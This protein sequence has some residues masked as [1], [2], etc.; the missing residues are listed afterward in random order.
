M[1]SS[2]PK[3]NTQIILNTAMQHIHV[4]E[5]KAGLELLHKLESGG[6]ND[7]R[8]FRTIGGVYERLGENLLARKYFI[9]SLEINPSQSD[10]HHAVAAN[11]L[12][13]GDMQ[14]A[15]HQC[16]K[17]LKIA[18]NNFNIWLVKAKCE[19]ELRH[20][21]SAHLSFQKAVD[22][23]PHDIQV[24]LHYANLQMKLGLMDQ[25]GTL[26]RKA[27]KIAPQDINVKV[28]YAWF[29]R[30]SGKLQDASLA[31]NRLLEV[32]TD[33]ADA[34]EDL[35]LTYLDLGEIQNALI[36]LTEGL[37]KQPKN[38][39]LHRTLCSLRYETGDNDYTASLR[40]AQ[41]EGKIEIAAE[42]IRQLIVGDELDQAQ[43]RL[44]KLLPDTDNILLTSVLQISIWKKQK[45]FT[46][47]IRFFEKNRELL[48]SHQQVLEIVVVALLAE[49]AYEQADALV[50]RLVKNHPFDQ[51]YL[52]L[53]GI[54]KRH[55][56]NE[57]YSYLCNFEQL[58]SA[59]ELILPSHYKSL[60]SFNSLL[61][62]T[63]NDV[64][65]MQQN[66]LSQS[67]RGGTQTSGRLF[68]RPHPIIRDLKS[69]LATTAQRFLTTLQKDPSHP[70]TSRIGKDIELTA[71]WSIRLQNAGYHVPHI[72]SKGWYSSAY[73]VSLPEI[74]HDKSGWLGIGKSGIELQTPQETE[75]WIKP[76][77]GTL[78]LFPS[79]FWHGTE[80]FSDPQ[81][82]LSVAF[83]IL[84]TY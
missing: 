6:L 1:N 48:I 17:A 67:V 70:I 24:L 26:L 10:L 11:Q 41:S 51:F 21:G 78:V 5:L 66:P 4:G 39:S 59:Q 45:R 3:Q 52:A 53:K 76:E 73:Y 65:S 80:P 33:T 49:A 47:I 29:L 71:S 36:T 60:D 20:Y 77:V 44:F 61:A 54:V 27:I 12:K 9:L 63:L 35:A 75:L 74:T 8:L 68:D 79:C 28:Q 18:P 22:L 19:V 57:Y 46:D 81:E 2:N 32:R 40:L 15:L 31:F 55:Q 14:S 58:V 56:L 34:Y 50:E 37:K 62:E 13:C 82:R 83:D 30:Q 72:H 16:E 38:I 23:N 42:L 25:A 43:T 7:F 64:H 69:S 84:P